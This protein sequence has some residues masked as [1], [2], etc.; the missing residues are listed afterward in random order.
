MRKHESELLTRPQVSYHAGFDLSDDA[1]Y[2]I[3]LPTSI[4]TRKATLLTLK[5]R[6]V[7]QG[8]NTVWMNKLE[9]LAEPLILRMVESARNADAI[10]LS[11]NNAQV[12]GMWAQKTALTFELTTASRKVANVEMGKRLQSGSPLRGAMVWAA[13]HPQDY[14][15][16]IGLVHI[17]ISRTPDPQPGPPDRQILLVGIVYHLMTL[18]VYITDAPGQL[19]PP[20]PPDGWQLI[21]PAFGL[22]EF[23]PMRV[24]HGTEVRE[25]LT[26]HSTWLPLVN[27]TGIRRSLEPP[28][29]AHR[30]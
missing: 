25:I 2:F 23:P 5:T 6:E 18:L 20:I 14:D 10:I 19:P 28:Q 11:K 3:E 8:C 12:L 22:V 4:I 1:K 13:R 16:G 30:N 27:H 15:L 29:V 9:Q 24:V 21:W 7:C 17:D 26:N